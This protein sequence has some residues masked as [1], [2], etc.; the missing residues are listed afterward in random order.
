MSKTE[1]EQLKKKYYNEAI[2]Y[3]DN[4]KETLKKAGKDDGVYLDDKYVRVACGTAYSGVLKALDGYLYLKGVEKKKGRKS[5][6][7]YYEHLSR[8]DQRMLSYMHDAYEILHL[9]GY[10]D[11][12]RTAK[13]IQAGFSVAYDIIKKIKPITNA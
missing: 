2:R 8:L 10:Y 1:Q 9:S 4:A 3:M 7:F 6:E 11:G 5:I 12:L 13:T